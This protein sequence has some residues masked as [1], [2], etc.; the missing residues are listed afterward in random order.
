MNKELPKPVI[1]LDDNNRI[2]VIMPN[3]DQF[4]IEAMNTNVYPNT[5]MVRLN[6]SENN[7]AIFPNVTNEVMLKSAYKHS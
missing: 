2:T 4:T 1:E 5:L 3:G 7:L 6:H